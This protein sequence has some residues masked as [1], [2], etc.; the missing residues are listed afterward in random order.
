MLVVIKS[1]LV[2]GGLVGV[3]GSDNLEHNILLL[4][5]IP[6]KIKTDVKKFCVSV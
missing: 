4:S 6:Y 3:G 2:L 1:D 5:I